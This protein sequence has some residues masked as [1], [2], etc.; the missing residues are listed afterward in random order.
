MNSKSKASDLKLRQV[1]TRTWQE[2]AEIGGS[3]SCKREGN[4]YMSNTDHNK[5]EVEPCPI[6]REH[7]GTVCV[8][9]YV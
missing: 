8:R 4:A 7:A 6:E 1:S 9:R 5:R 2:P 3:G